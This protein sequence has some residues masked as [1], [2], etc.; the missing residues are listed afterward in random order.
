MRKLEN[1]QVLE[2]HE[3]YAA[4]L[5][6]RIY[7]QKVRLPGGR[8]VDDYHRIGLPDCIIVYAETDDGKVV[9]ERQYK[10]GPGSVG[11]SLPAG[12]IDAGEDP[13]A[14]AQRELLEE[15]GYEARDWKLAGRYAVNGNY[16]CGFAYMYLA[17]GAKRVAT[18]ESG[19]LEHIEI[20]LLDRE[21][22]RAS[23]YN[24]EVHLLAAVT[25]ILLGLAKHG[26]D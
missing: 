25:G 9:V 15:T 4:D 24:G 20:E 26:K 7:K 11:L 14:C 5:W 18:P 23:V 13:L 17:S 8:V 19:D 16:G 3:V 1:W 22:L 2:S 10:H 6:L 21:Q 12:A